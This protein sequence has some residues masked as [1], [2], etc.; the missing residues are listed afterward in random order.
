MF[1]AYHIYLFTVLVSI[2]FNSYLCASAA[3]IAEKTNS[4][5]DAFL[6]VGTHDDTA[7]TRPFSD[8]DIERLISES[9]LSELQKPE[10]LSSSLGVLATKPLNFPILKNPDSGFIDTSVDPPVGPSQPF[11]VKKIEYSL[12]GIQ[13]ASV[14]A[15]STST[16]CAQ[17]PNNPSVRIRSVC[18][19]TGTNQNDVPVNPKL[20][21]RP[22]RPDPLIK[23][24]QNTDQD[25]N[26]CNEHYQS[27]S[28]SKHVSCG[29]PTVMQGHH[30]VQF[31]FNCVL[32]EARIRCYQPPFSLTNAW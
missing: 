15:D 11:Q 26:P 3:L 31:V 2:L 10:D 12:N 27:F 24:E 8:E 22:R 9:S 1:P 16:D 14:Y 28:M 5:E 23:E 32:G 30:F 18:P 6:D 20:L 7:L 25:E 19:A 17:K 13:D 21:T 29:G 4:A